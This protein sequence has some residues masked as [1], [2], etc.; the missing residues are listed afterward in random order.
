VLA[1]Q[2]HVL[3]ASSRP[4]GI[5]ETRFSHFRRLTLSPLS[6]TQEEQALTQ[7]LGADDATELLAYVTE[8]LPL[9]TETRDRVT[10]N[11]LMLSMLASVVVLRRGV[12]MPSRV[13]E[14]YKD[15]AEAM[16]ARGGVVSPRLQTLLQRVFFEAHVAQSR[17][18]ENW[19]LCEAALALAQP[20]KL[21]VIHKRAL[22]RVLARP[23][24]WWPTPQPAEARFEEH[25]GNPE[26]GHLV[27]VVDGWHAGVCHYPSR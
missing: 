8:K 4:A 5:D 26:V 12:S 16:L 27:E 13:A 21:A 1:L 25:M 24:R 20:E 3:L 14:L 9:N 18:I 17:E 23:R 19:Q 11:P 22:A 10:S 6:E 15:A 7:R 2:G